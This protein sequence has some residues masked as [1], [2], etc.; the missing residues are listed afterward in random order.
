MG[1]AAAEIDWDGVL[2]HFIWIMGLAILAVT[3]WWLMR[4]YRH[5]YEEQ[6][7]L[8]GKARLVNE[9]LEHITREP[10]YTAVVNTIIRRIG[11]EA[12]ADRCYIYIYRKA[13]A[14][15][16][17]CFEWVAPGIAPAIATQ[18]N[19]DMQSFPEIQTRLETLTD[20]VVNRVAELPEPS[21]SH[22]Q[23]QMIQSLMLMPFRY[24]DGGVYGYIGID[25]V[26]REHAFSESDVR[27]M[28]DAARL[29]ELARGRK[30]QQDDLL[31]SAAVQRQIFDHVDI[32]M[33]L[34]T[35]QGEVV[36]ANPAAVRVIGSTPAELVGQ[37]CHARVCGLPE[38]PAWCPLNET[39]RT[40]RCSKIHFSG[41]GERSFQV[42]TQPIFNPD[43]QLHYVL[44]TAVDVSELKERIA[45]EQ[46][47]NYCLETFFSA[48]DVMVAVHKVLQAITLHAKAAHCYIYRCDQVEEHGRAALFDSYTMD[49]RQPLLER[50]Q[51]VDF[52]LDE[53]WYQRLQQRDFVMLNDLDRPE[54]QNMLATWSE[55]CRARHLRS[56]YISGIWVDGRLWGDFGI[57]YEDEDGDCPEARLKLLHF[58]AHLLETLLSREQTARRLQEAMEKAQMAEKAKSSFLATMSHEL[59]TPLN[60][61]IGFSELLED[62]HVP[63]QEATEYV[64]CINVAGKALLAQI[65]DVL[66]LS[67]I[68]ADQVILVAAPTRIAGLFDEL[69]L[70]FRQ[71]ARNKQLTLSFEGGEAVPELLLD[72]L[73]VRQILLNLIGNAIKFTIHGGIV[74]TA[75]WDAGTLVLAVRDTGIGIDPDKQEAIFSPFVQQ[76]PSRDSQIQH[77]TGLGLAICRKLAEKMGGGISL[78]S[79][80]GEGST[81]TLR[82]PE[83]RRAETYD[84]GPAGCESDLQ[85]HP[86]ARVVL[87]VDDIP[88][89]LKLV[90][91][92]LTRLGMANFGATSSDEALKVLRQHPEIDTVLTDLW[93]PD[94]NGFELAR[95]IHGNPLWSRVKVVILTADS[96]C[97][98]E[99][100]DDCEAVLLKPVTRDK[101]QTC[102]VK[103]GAA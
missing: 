76:N 55:L 51:E 93:M 18:Q 37:P 16:D 30:K 52:R 42:T 40:G 48:D 103:L 36:S 7:E 63:L 28:H 73:R 5:R 65:N 97:R 70:I 60:A 87:V 47:M 22:L 23:T 20:V 81:F 33:L 38:R 86:D 3:A 71:S 98:P 50:F 57:I 11:E 89:N 84:A 83:V 14:V 15:V 4:K 101:L 24:P 96:E 34:F 12:V 62:R 64:R 59:R 74:V 72:E 66:E 91:S 27:T 77:G 94:T 17:C 67:K 78:V 2:F 95:M 75:G 43:G 21:R 69:E 100:P 46:M 32:P 26:R 99:H 8:I 54:Q 45:N 88:M 31:Q 68:E 61:V 102:L 82:L 92:M 39:C 29:F 56:A 58:A 85:P 19:L 9:C 1:G 44:E 90:R 13:S 41:H 79:R 80:P 49:G 25:F 53:P 10:D 6:R 35:P